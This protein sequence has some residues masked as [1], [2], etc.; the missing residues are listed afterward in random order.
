MNLFS[1]FIH[2]FSSLLSIHSFWFFSVLQTERSPKKNLKIY[3]VSF[4]FKTNKIVKCE[5]L[6]SKNN[7]R[8]LLTFYRAKAMFVLGKSGQNLFMWLFPSRLQWVFIEKATSKWIFFCFSIWPFV[9][10][11]HVS[12]HDHEKEWFVCIFASNKRANTILW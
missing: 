1:I 2:T 8:F 4:W 11:R 7:L 3:F 5:M 12:W 6:T 9:H 10:M